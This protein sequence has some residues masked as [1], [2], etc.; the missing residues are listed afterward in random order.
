MNL[1]HKAIARMAGYRVKEEY[2]WNNSP[3]YN[4]HMQWLYKWYDVAEGE[5]SCVS[6]WFDSEDEAWEA[7]CVNN[8]LIE[9]EV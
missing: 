7:C 4:T 9:E 2:K 6:S 8:N 1:T 5:E 3:R